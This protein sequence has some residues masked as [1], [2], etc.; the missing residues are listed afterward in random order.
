[1]R[2]LGGFSHASDHLLERH[3]GRGRLAR[4]APG[5]A[6]HGCGGQVLQYRAVRL[7]LLFLKLPGGK[8]THFPS[9]ERDV[10]DTELRAKLPESLVLGSSG[11]DGDVGVGKGLEVVRLHVQVVTET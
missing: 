1:M 11:L 6:V 10:G 7:E 4:D 5:L 3:A 9:S 2:S 8:S